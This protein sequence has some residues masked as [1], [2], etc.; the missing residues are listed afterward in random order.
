[1]KL[2]AYLTSACEAENCEYDIFTLLITSC[3]SM[4]KV[5]QNKK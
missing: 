3:S 4:K 5:L 2:T 1:M